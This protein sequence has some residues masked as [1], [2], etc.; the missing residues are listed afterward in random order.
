MIFLAVAG[1]PVQ[2]EA[3][4]KPFEH[5]AGG[6]RRRIPRTHLLQLGRQIHFFHHVVI[7]V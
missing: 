1:E 6:K 7:V 4:M 5:V 2:D 3:D